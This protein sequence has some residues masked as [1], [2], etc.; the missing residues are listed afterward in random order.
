MTVGSAEKFSLRP[1]TMADLD[2]IWAIEAAVFG[3]DAWSRDL[4]R[5]ELAAD[6]RV[7]RAL[8]DDAGVVVGYG[9]L[10]AVGTD[11]DI[12]TIAVVPAARGG[13]LGRRLMEAL[14]QAACERGVREVFLE[15]RAD[16]PVARGL[17]ESLGFEE[18]GVRPRYYQPGNVDAIVMR[19]TERGRK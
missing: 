8:V 4:M 15:V 12:Q 9:G 7:Y 14:L 19:R 17:Y 11:G 16:N 5:E 6:H 1:A 10:L 2:E 3:D 18:I 13:G